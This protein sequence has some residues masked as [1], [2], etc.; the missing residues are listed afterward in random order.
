LRE[1]A[2]DKLEQMRMFGGFGVGFEKEYFKCKEKD[3]PVEEFEDRV[4]LYE[5]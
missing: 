3:E 4:M 2:A 5:L 1:G